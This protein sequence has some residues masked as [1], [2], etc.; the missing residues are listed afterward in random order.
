MFLTSFDI[1]RYSRPQSQKIVS[2]PSPQYSVISFLF[3]KKKEKHFA[4]STGSVKF[5]DMTSSKNE[6]KDRP[7]RSIRKR[8]KRKNN[9]QD[10]QE[11][12]KKPKSSP[13]LGIPLFY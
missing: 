9:N 7:K 10:R 5:L 2:G 8:P 1:I 3:Y 11:L 6:G 4:K 13:P 12:D